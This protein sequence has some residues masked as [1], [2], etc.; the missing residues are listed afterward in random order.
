MHIEIFRRRGLCIVIIEEIA[1]R[2]NARVLATFR[3]AAKATKYAKRI[4]ENMSLPVFN[5]LQ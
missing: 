5:G 2:T 4:G 3:S 1:N